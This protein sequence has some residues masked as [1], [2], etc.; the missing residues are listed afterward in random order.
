[1]KCSLGISDFLEEI[2]IL[3]HSIDFLYFFV[4]PDIRNM[5]FREQN[6]TQI[7]TVMLW[8]GVLEEGR[9]RKQPL[10][11]VAQV[12]NW[13]QRNQRRGVEKL[14]YLSCGEWPRIYLLRG[15]LSI[16]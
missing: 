14:K 8:N 4:F 7:K 9:V 11:T 16:L 15:Q 1:M 6:S 12:I 10:S 2:S 5:K 13:S 3:S